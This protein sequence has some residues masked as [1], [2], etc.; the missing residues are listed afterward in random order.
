MQTWTIVFVT[1]LGNTERSRVVKN[2]SP[3]I[4]IWNLTVWKRLGS[5]L[6]IQKIIL[7]ISGKGLITSIWVSR[8]KTRPKK[9]K[10]ARYAIGNLSKN[11]LSNIIREF[12]KLLYNSYDRRRPKHE[13]TESYLYIAI[14][15]AKYMMR[16]DACNS[17]NYPVRTE[18]TET[19]HIPISHAC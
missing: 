16:D 9:Y 17:E 14:Q 18:M 10:K 2:M 6:H 13:P 19:K 4:Y 12:D 7:G 5:H 11:Y 15:I 3:W 8:P 1:M